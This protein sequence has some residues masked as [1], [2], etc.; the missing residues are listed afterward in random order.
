MR[1]RGYP[2]GVAALSAVTVRTVAGSLVE[3][4]SSSVTR[5]AIVLAL[6]WETSAEILR[7]LPLLLVS[8]AAVQDT[9]QASWF[10]LHPVAVLMIDGFA[11]LARPASR[12]APSG[13]ERA[14]R[15][16]IRRRD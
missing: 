14:R 9:S 10:V 12:S 7:M 8:P 2:E 3:S 13:I 1:E 5:E 15:R 4:Q 11:A 16:R 6:S